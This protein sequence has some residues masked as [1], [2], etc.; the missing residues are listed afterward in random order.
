MQ[1]IV[2]LLLAFVVAF[3]AADLLT[4]KASEDNVLGSPTH[5]PIFRLLRESKCLTE[6]IS[7]FVEALQF[8]YD[9]PILALYVRGASLY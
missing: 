1:K 9:A 5:R 7:E 2:L 3:A 8:A 6:F 4:L